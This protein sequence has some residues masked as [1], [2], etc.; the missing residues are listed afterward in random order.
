MNNT[1]NIYPCLPS[2]HFSNETTALCLNL[3]VEDLMLSWNQ[4]CETKLSHWHS[5]SPSITSLPSNSP[6][7][8]QCQYQRT[9]SS[10]VPKEN[11]SVLHSLLTTTTTPPPIP[12]PLQSGHP[13][14][15]SC[16]HQI[17]PIFRWKDR[18]T[19]SKL[20][21]KH[22]QPSK[23]AKRKLLFKCK[24]Q[25]KEMKFYTYNWQ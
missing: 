5:S 19:S 15:P 24:N 10:S 25:D 6:S 18:S 14:N 17:S 16:N 21:S 3:D 1:S 7:N 8:N 4:L 13:P 20:Y 12:P 11:P 9:D 22:K 2:E 23:I